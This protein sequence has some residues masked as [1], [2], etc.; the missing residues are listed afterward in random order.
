MELAREECKRLAAIAE[1]ME[2]GADAYQLNRELVEYL[3]ELLLV[4]MSGNTKLVNLADD[5]REVMNRQAERVDVSRLVNW[6]KAFNQA[7]LEMRLGTHLQLPLEL[8]FVSVLVDEQPVA[9]VAASR[10]RASKP[11]PEKTAEGESE[12]KAGSDDTDV[13]VFWGKRL[14]DTVLAEIYILVFVYKNMCVT[15][16]KQFGCFR[17]CFKFDNGF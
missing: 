2:N 8:A 13:A 14:D 15:A 3:R 7:S 5:E 6:T 1:A 12:A 10:T 4:K 16:A 11:L 9:A 17:V